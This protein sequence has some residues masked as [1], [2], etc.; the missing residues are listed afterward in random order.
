[1]LTLDDGTE[2]WFCH[3]T[4]IFVEVGETV[5]A[6]EVIGTVGTTGHVT[7]SHLHVEVRPGGGD[8]VDPYPAF[9]MHGVTP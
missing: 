1:V 7:G 8:P 6:G 9:V 3:Q 2:I 5:T 4:E